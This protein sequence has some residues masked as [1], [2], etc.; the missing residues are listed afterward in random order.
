VDGRGDRS[1]DVCRRG[2]WHLATGC[3]SKCGA[4]PDFPGQSRD[5]KGETYPPG[6]LPHEFFFFCVDSR[7]SAVAV[8]GTGFLGHPAIP[9]MPRRPAHLEPGS[10]RTPNFSKFPSRKRADDG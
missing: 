4:I 5:F 7:A 10:R 6:P 1:S 8:I 9:V 2:W 3:L